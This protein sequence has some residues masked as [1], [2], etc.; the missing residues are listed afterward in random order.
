MLLRCGETL[1]V[2]YIQCHQHLSIIISMPWY[3]CCKYSC[4][5]KQR[6]TKWNFFV[7]VSTKLEKIVFC[8]NYLFHIFFFSKQDVLNFTLYVKAAVSAG[9][10]DLTQLEQVTVISPSLNKSRWSLEVLPNWDMLTNCLHFSWASL[11]VPL[12][13][14]NLVTSK[15]AVCSALFLIESKNDDAIIYR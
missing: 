14:F 13:L 15:K 2:V 8:S 12:W 5:W 3:S 9:H 1:G 4:F 7:V 11:C 6:F 10:R